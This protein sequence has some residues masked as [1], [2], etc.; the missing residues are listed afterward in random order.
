MI[1]IKVYNDKCLI[2]NNDHDHGLLP[3]MYSEAVKNELSYTVPSHE[4]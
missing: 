2:V 3:Q 1:E 4:W